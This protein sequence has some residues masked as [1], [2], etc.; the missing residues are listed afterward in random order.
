MLLG[1]KVELV[2]FDHLNRRVPGGNQDQGGGLQVF[3]PLEPGPLT[4][5]KTQKQVL[6]QGHAV[7]RGPAQTG[8]DELK[9][10]GQDEPLVSAAKIGGQVPE[11][12]VEQ[13]DPALGLVDQ[14]E[15]KIAVGLKEPPA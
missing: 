11:N 12:I 14:G 10:A 8:G 1:L 6:G 2:E 3:N 13:R 9:V 5:G 7:K 15:E 4:Q